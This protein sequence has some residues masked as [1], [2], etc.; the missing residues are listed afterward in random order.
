MFG[1]VSNRVVAMAMVV[2]I[3][4]CA[5]KYQPMGFTGGY[6]DQSLGDNVYLIQVNVNAY[7]SAATAYRYFHRR[8][9]E[10]CQSKGFSGYRVLD[11][12]GATRR[13]LVATGQNVTYHEKPQ[14]FGRVECLAEG[15]GV[16]PSD[17]ERSSRTGTAFMVTVLGHA[18][19]NAHVVESCGQ[20]H[21]HLPSGPEPAQLIAADRANDLALLQVAREWGRY[22]GLASSV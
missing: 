8:A 1:R 10:L 2:V 17:P 4:G 11:E 6:T 19:T 13:T 12:G 22:A 16:R 3:A 15:A 21:I 18:V 5:T 20:V 7:T 14:H 9:Q